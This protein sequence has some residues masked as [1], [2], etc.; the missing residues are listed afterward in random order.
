M[1]STYPARITSTSPQEA[2]GEGMYRGIV[3]IVTAI[4]CSATLG[5]GSN[6]PGQDQ[7]SGPSD[8]RGSTFKLVGSIESVPRSL[9]PRVV[10]S[11]TEGAPQVLGSD[12]CKYFFSNGIRTTSDAIVLP[13]RIHFGRAKT[14]TNARCSGGI[15]GPE[16]LLTNILRSGPEWALTR[17]G[18]TLRL[19]SHQTVLMLQRVN[20]LELKRLM[21]GR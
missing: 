9:Q 15:R 4:A 20:G 17:D 1:A 5:C 3:C 8:L 11:F 7:E 19:T 16:R 21:L 18:G 2:K 13:Y 10:M 6:D 12:G 14:F